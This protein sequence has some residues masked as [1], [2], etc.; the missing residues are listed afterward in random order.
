[1]KKSNSSWILKLFILVALMLTPSLVNSHPA[2]A[3]SGMTMSKLHVSGNQ[4]VNSSGQPV[5]LTDGINPPVRIG[6]TRTANIIWINTA[7]TD[8]RRFWRI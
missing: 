8:M 5:L 7:G 4:L 3:W 2:K 6:R 1:M